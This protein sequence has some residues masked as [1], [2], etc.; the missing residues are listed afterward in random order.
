MLFPVNFYFSFFCF[1]SIKHIT[2]SFVSSS[3]WKSFFVF[4]CSPHT[5]SFYPQDFQPCL[6]LDFPS[7]SFHSWFRI[8]CSAFRKFPALP[9]KFSFQK[10]IPDFIACF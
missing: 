5:K 8:F 9:V 6:F 4:V 7:G 10:K 3:V 1:Y 2:L